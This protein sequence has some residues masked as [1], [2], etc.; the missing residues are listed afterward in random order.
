MN[1]LEIII[2]SIGIILFTIIFIDDMTYHLRH[3]GRR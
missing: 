3:K 1:P 2:P